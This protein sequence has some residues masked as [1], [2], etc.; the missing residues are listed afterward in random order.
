VDNVE[1]LSTFFVDNSPHAKKVIHIRAFAEMEI[2]FGERDDGEKKL[3]T[4]FV[5]N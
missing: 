5:D 3:S 2:L 1:N 4:F